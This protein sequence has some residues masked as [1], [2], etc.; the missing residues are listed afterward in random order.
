MGQAGAQP[1]AWAAAP[2]LLALVHRPFTAFCQVTR[3]PHRQHMEAEAAAERSLPAGMCLP[4]PPAG[5][6]S[7]LSQEVDQ[8]KKMLKAGANWE[9]ISQVM[10]YISDKA[11]QVGAAP[12]A[13]EPHASAAAAALLLLLLLPMCFAPTSG[14]CC[15][16]AC[17]VWCSVFPNGTAQ[18]SDECS[19]SRRLKK[20]SAWQAG[21]GSFVFAQCPVCSAGPASR[22]STAGPRPAPLCPLRSWSRWLPTWLLARPPPSPGPCSAWAPCWAASRPRCGV[23]QGG[24]RNFVEAAA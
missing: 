12:A 7:V 4:L 10:S 2:Q 8:L 9:V 13:A 6:A 16:K 1:E 14:C 11:A 18:L 3:L 19:A 24:G 15:R 23:G 21:Q 17:Y 20:K 5:Q 22:R